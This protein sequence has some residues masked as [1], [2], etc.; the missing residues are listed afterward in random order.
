MFIILK[1]QK[2]SYFPKYNCKT[3]LFNFFFIG[4]AEIFEEEE[5]ITK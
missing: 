4:G 1:L 5:S 2:E 3:E